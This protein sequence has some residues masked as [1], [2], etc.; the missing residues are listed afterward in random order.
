[1]SMLMIPVVI[2][3]L[4]FTGLLFAATTV[5]SVLFF[6]GPPGSSV[7]RVGRALA[8]VCGSLLGVLLCAATFLGFAARGTMVVHGHD[9]P[10]EII[11]HPT[12][13]SAPS[14][15]LLAEAEEEQ[16]TPVSAESTS[17]AAGHEDRTIS[18]AP[19]EWTLAGEVRHGDVRQI[20]L[21]SKQFSTLDEARND[22]AATARN[23][24][25]KDFESVYHTPAE[26]LRQLPLKT[27][28]D[29]AVK[30]EHVETV[31][32]DFGSFFAPMHRVWWQVEVSP[33]V[34][35]NL[36]PVWKAAVQEQRTITVAG[37]L[38]AATVAFAGLSLL[39]R[40]RR[41]VM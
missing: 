21:S 20:V 40:R 33:D 23:L 27:L 12:A 7:S 16:I 4:V 17:P 13:H 10:R 19:P 25:A 6:A 9:A 22:I 37:T 2:L 36:H 34:R 24:L 39:T 3:A 29:V 26:T 31:E 18:A 32:R 35:T 30:Q 14:Q 8:V 1:M 11:A 5:G 15:P 41:A 28:T 38:A